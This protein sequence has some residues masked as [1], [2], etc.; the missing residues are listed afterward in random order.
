LPERLVVEQCFPSEFEAQRSDQA[1]TNPRTLIGATMLAGALIIG[2][3]G[4]SQPDPNPPIVVTGNPA[5]GNPPGPP[6][7]TTSTTIPTTTLY[8]AEK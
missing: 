1:M 8:Y 4:C 2:A 6:T 7:T 3:T 5:L